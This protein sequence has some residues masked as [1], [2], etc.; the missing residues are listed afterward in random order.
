MRFAKKVDLNC[1]SLAPRLADTI[2]TKKE[3]E[4]E[5]GGKEEKGRRRKR[6]ER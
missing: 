4:N 5:R 2:Y 3:G 6:K 1:P